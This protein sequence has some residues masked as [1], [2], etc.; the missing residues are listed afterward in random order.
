VVGAFSVL[1]SV[2]YVILG[3]QEW[4][5]ASEKVCYVP[6]DLQTNHVNYPVSRKGKRITLIACICVDGSFMRPVLVISRKTFEDELLLFGC[7]PDKVEIYDHPNAYIDRD[8]FTDWFRDTFI[9]E[10][11]ARREK[12]NYHGPAF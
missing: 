12:H 3:H 10:I 8:I 6:A 2:R 7:T 4:A 1:I 9:T 11:Q 5:D